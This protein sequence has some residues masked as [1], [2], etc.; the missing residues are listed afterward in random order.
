VVAAAWTLAGAGPAAPGPRPPLF[1]RV[2]RPVAPIITSAYSTEA[3]RDGHGEAERV[4]SR[5]GVGPGMRVAD[6]GAGDGYYTVRVA[7]RLGRTGAVYAQ[8]VEPRSLERLAA[9]LAREKISGVTLVQGTP[10]DPKLP[11]RS[12]DLAILSHMY[13]EIAEPYEFLY[14]LH[15]ALRPGGRV[16]VV[17][18][19]KPVPEHG[20]PPLLLRCELERV[21]YRQVDALVLAPADGYLAVF[22]SAEVLPAPD[23]IRPCRQGRQRR[24]PR[25]SGPPSPPA[26]PGAPR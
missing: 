2:D 20:S 4:L 22:S 18:N 15:R 14:R 6:V 5:L 26:L 8:D 19:D 10:A 16:A 12:V 21:G 7:S 24:A 3:E 11:E 1:P 25:R 23:G 9:R 13:H 17:D